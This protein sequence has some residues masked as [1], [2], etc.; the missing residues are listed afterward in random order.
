MRALIVDDSKTMRSIISRTIRELG[1][2][3]LE[4]GNGNEGLEQLQ[5]GGPVE[6]TL[7]DWNM[8]E[9]NGL[10]F[11]E[12]VRTKSAYS[13]MKMMMITTA[14][15]ESNITRALEAGADEYLMKPFTKDALVTKLQMLGVMES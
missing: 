14:A 9:M 15:D 10:Q 7:V 3:I 12:A 2:E 4:A 11:V 1:F 13:A 6:L 8:P 5:R